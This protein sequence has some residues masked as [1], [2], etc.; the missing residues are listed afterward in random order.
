MS[1]Q[2]SE[3][4]NPQ[5]TRKTETESICR[6]CFLTVKGDRYASI[7][8]AERIHADVC[9]MRPGSPVRYVIY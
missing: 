1:S 2:D 9:L 5:F 3:D 6:L 4:Q 7:Q 8:E